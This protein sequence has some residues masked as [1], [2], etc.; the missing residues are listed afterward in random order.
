M[1]ESQDLGVQW[2]AVESKERDH[3][4]EMCELGYQSNKGK[5]WLKFKTD[6]IA[7]VN[8]SDSHLLMSLKYAKI[9]VTEL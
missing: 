5:T 6:S 2:I 3:D 7:F 1:Q 9:E 8:G 4:G